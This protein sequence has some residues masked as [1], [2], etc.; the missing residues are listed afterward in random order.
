MIWL[1]TTAVL[2]APPSPLQQHMQGHFAHATD[3]MWYVASADLDRAK[4]DAA[5]LDHPASDSLPPNLKPL[6]ENLRTASR[7]LATAD[8]LDAAASQVGRVTAQCAACHVSADRGPRV[9]DDKVSRLGDSGPSHL[10]GVY[11]LWIG[12]VLP[13]NGA[14]M[15]G[16][17]LLHSDKVAKHPKYAT[18]QAIAKT[19][20][21]LTEAAKKAEIH[22][23]REEVFGKL[24]GTCASCHTQL[25]VDL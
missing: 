8:D 9:E 14:W 16:A 12:L 4:E 25:G 17:S 19:F 13:D 22:A 24:L 21:E 15:E 10:W 7:A 2:A 6:V 1:I 3:A 18:V 11:G 23:D 5:H 20:D